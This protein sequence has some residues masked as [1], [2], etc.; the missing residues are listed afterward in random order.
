MFD[1]TNEKLSGHVNYRIWRETVIYLPTLPGCV[2]KI[3]R[4][5]RKYFY[6]L[7]YCLV[8]RPEQWFTR[9]LQK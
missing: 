2:M 9:A 7:Q 6:I 3:S 5:K 8:G 1:P 4:Q